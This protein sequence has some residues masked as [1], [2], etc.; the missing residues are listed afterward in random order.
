MSEFAEVLRKRNKAM[1]IRDTNLES[2][3]KENSMTFLITGHELKA[4][5]EWEKNH[6]CQF[7]DDALNPVNPQG[8]IGGGTTYSFTPTGLGV[9]TIIKC[10]CGE[11]KNIT[12]YE[13]W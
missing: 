10:A 7:Y 8:A 5:Y 6:R 9:A 13:S 1:M 2:Y 3:F 12:D 11:E 4:L